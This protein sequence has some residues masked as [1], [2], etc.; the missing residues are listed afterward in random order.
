MKQPLGK[1]ILILAIG[2]LA[3]STAAIWSRLA[4]EAAGKRD[5]GFS[6]VLA[7]SRLT[8]ASMILLP[9]WRQIQRGEELKRALPYAIGAG[10]F[11]GV[12]FACWISS[13]AYTSIAAST[14]FV[15]TNP[16]WVALIS[17]VWLKEKISRKTIAGIAIA[18]GG[19]LVI[20]LADSGNHAGTN[21]LLGNFLAIAGSWAVSFYLLLGREAQKLGL[22]VGG[23]GAIAYTTA[24]IVLL[25]MPILFGNG[26]SGYPTPV[27]LYI[28]LMAIFPQLVGH[29]SLNWAMGWVSPT[30]VTLSILFE[31]VFASSLG[32]FIFGEVPPSQVFLGAAVLL[33]GVA[34]AAMGDREL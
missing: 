30:L 20:G 21:P 9:T 33:T 1:V 18:L 16:V 28:L 23:Y 26:Y 8:L 3:V 27:Y 24:A 19:G 10:V 32:Y 14:T 22:T 7:A 13:L 12:H 29:T 2:V 17:W 34:I 25:P 4:F 15:T 6:L 11:L 5:V 31:P